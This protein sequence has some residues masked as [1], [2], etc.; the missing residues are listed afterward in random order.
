MKL[1]TSFVLVMS[2]AAIAEA[3]PLPEPM[4][5]LASLKNLKPQEVT[6]IDQTPIGKLEIDQS[7]ILKPTVGGIQLSRQSR[8]SK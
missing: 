7:D 2:A 5:G 6:P 4:K 3:A 1:S 8:T